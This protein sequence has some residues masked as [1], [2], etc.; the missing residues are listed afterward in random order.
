MNKITPAKTRL[1]ALYLVALAF[2]SCVSQEEWNRKADA[3]YQKAFAAAKADG[4]TDSYA[5]KMGLAARHDAVE[6]LADDALHLYPVHAND[7]SHILNAAH[8][9][10]PITTTT[11]CPTTGH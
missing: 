1:A 7:I 5:R 10:P 9:S 3:E 8:N 4:R 11:V 2:T 6:N